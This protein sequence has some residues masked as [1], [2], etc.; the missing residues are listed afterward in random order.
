[1]LSSLKKNPIL[2]WL[3]SIKITVVCLILLFILTFWGTVA[4][5]TQGLY[6]AQEIFFNSWY[7]LAFDFL[8]FPGAQLVLWVLFFNLCA[9]SITRFVYKWSHIGILII[10]LGLI[11]YFVSAFVTLHFVEESNVTLLEGETSNVSAA[12]HDW[13]ISVWEQGQSPL[14]DI[15][16][17]DVKFLQ[18]EQLLD[19]NHLGFSLRVKSYFPNAQAYTG[20]VEE[21]SRPLNV[22][23]ITQIT[24]LDISSEPEK[25]FPAVLL[26]MTSGKQTSD[27]ILFGKEGRPTPV[28]I[29][30]K[31]MYFQIR[32]KRYELP[33]TI[34]LNKFEMEKHPGTEIAS[35]YR[36]FIEFKHGDIERKA[37]IYMNHPLRFK[38]Y[39]FYQASYSIDQMGRMR[40]TLAVVKNFGRLLPYISSLL[41]FAGL[42]IHFLLMA[43]KRKK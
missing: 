22:S 15:S 43:F 18:T 35:K 24:R 5:V 10:H 19:F 13:E 7:F 38:N 9:V 30:G 26:E 17:Y 28:E 1:M 39:T 11:T 32:R 41:T 25:N 16:A 6:Q 36:S 21:G 31:S 12:Y 42:A 2:K 40:S 33:I 34:T 14:R 3:S 20:S 23:G 37:E 4:Q 29:N 8:P 27:V